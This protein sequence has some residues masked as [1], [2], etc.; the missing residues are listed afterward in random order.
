[1][2]TKPEMN[3]LE[4]QSAPEE[5]TVDSLLADFDSASF[6]SA[7]AQLDATDKAAQ[8]A[9]E[10][11]KQPEEDKTSKQDA[12]AAV[13]MAQ[14]AF[15]V[16]ENL[17]SGLTGIEFKY[18]EASK[19]GVLE[20]LEP[21]IEKHGLTWLG[22]FDKY[23]EEIVFAIAFGGLA[24]TSWMQLKKATAQKAIQAQHEKQRAQFERIKQKE[25]ELEKAKQAIAQSA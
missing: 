19:N 25:A 23:R 22:W 7:L 4:S 20:A 3:E 9:Q 17:I 5:L 16:S 21:L 15:I 2:Q 18:D 24:F 11:T 12:K 8:E 14:T 1:M 13:G 10:A 6:D